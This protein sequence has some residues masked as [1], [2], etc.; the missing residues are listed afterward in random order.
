MSELKYALNLAT[1]CTAL[2]DMPETQLDSLKLFIKEKKNEFPS[3]IVISGVRII[4]KSIDDLLASNELSATRSSLSLSTYLSTT[5]SISLVTDYV[6]LT[7]AHN[8]EISLATVGSNFELST[9]R[10]PVEAKR[11]YFSIA[12]TGNGLLSW[13]SNPR[14]TDWVHHLPAT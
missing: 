14:Y 10:Y 2:T 12:T 6:G 3:K 13:N 8:R 11:A 9:S 4:R 7:M 1:V 5:L